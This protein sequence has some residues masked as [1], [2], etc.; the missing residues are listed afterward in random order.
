MFSWSRLCAYVR[1]HDRAYVC[2]HAWA[3][4]RLCVRIARGL[5]GMRIPRANKTR[6]NVMIL[7][8]MTVCTHMC[9]QSYIHE[10]QARAQP[11]M[12]S[13]MAWV[14]MVTTRQ[15]FKMQC[16]SADLIITASKTQV[17]QR[18]SSWARQCT[19]VKSNTNQSK[20]VLLILKYKSS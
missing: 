1:G 16:S 15:V 18:R 7:K 8:G 5:V 12:L 3:W 11:Q 2:I 6:P 10:T 14:F 4:S 13:T 17:T 19:R 20:F 9:V